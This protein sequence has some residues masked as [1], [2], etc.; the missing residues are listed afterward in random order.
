GF[1]FSG[2]KNG[3]YLYQKELSLL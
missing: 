1:Q 3:F 2:K